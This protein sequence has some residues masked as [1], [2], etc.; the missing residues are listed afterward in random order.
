MILGWS[1]LKKK[2]VLSLSRGESGFCS[3][4]TKHDRRMAPRLKLFVLNRRLQKESIQPQ[5]SVLGLSSSED[6]SVAWRLSTL[7][8]L[9]QSHICLFQQGD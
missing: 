4:K 3:S 7:E 1:E 2:T 8:D 5:K 6:F 9:R